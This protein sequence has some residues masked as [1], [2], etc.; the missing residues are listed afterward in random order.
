MNIH[1]IGGRGH[2]RHG[3]VR[4]RAQSAIILALI[5]IL[6][7]SI[8]NHSKPLNVSKESY[9][10]LLEL[11][12]QAESRNNYNAYFG[13]SRNSSIKFTDMSIAEVMQW[14]EDFIEQGSPSSAVGRY[15]IISTTLADLVQATGIS[16]D[17]LFDESMQDRLAIVL[18]E[19]RG[20]LDYINS[21]ISRH[22]FAANLAMEWASL[23]KVLGEGNL[24]SS[25]YDGDGLNRSLVRAESV[26][27]A[28]SKIESDG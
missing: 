22:R 16:P 6:A 1:L 26:L 15:Q 8:M 4:D 13:N 20:S 5:I 3:I 24:E 21:K 19:R 25:Y 7:L 2:F 28:I 9:K 11:I 17:R 23:P 14:Q 27:G 18:L 10:P 12:A